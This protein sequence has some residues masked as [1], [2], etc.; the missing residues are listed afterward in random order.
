MHLLCGGFAAQHA[1][2]DAEA[3]TGDIRKE[4][5]NAE[6]PKKS[7]QNET[8]NMMGKTS[9]NINS[10]PVTG[11]NC[12]KQGPGDLLCRVQRDITG[13][14]V[15]QQKFFFNEKDLQVCMAQE[16][17]KRKWTVHMEYHVP[18]T[19]GF[20]AGSNIRY[21]WNEKTMYVDLVVEENNLFV[22]VELKYK[23]RAIKG[24]PMV[25]RFGEEIKTDGIIKNQ[26][27]QDIG[28]YAFWKDVKRLELLNKRFDNVV[29]GI[30]VFVTN[31]ST[32]T[33]LPKTDR[34]PL[35]GYYDFRM[36]DP[37]NS[38]ISGRLSWRENGER[39]DKDIPATLC[40]FC[41]DGQYVI[42]QWESYTSA[43][44]KDFGKNKMS[45]MALPVT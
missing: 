38:V 9:E 29:G 45:F 4:A 39:T 27:A 5:E 13:I 6:N 26:S 19:D 31:D 3:K 22:P 14:L 33:Y 21:P 28:R 24:Q 30:A 41:L 8:T 17:T 1:S 37:K 35:V 18:V 43:H 12:P 40:N 16:L 20:V 42:P 11:Q 7:R 23:T 2:E 15:E 36:Y 34:P 25:Y 32:Y 44:N 10:S